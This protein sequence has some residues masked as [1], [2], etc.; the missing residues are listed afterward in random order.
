MI[1]NNE[2]YIWGIRAAS[3]FMK[4]ST[5]TFHKYYNEGKI[6]KEEINVGK[7]NLKGWKKS[8]LQPFADNP[9][10]MGRPKKKKD[11]EI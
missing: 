2:E 7:E 10:K 9:P 8:T 6:P 11:T 1:A 3:K 5:R 4:M